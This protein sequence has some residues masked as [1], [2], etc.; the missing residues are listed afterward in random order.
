V[1]AAKPIDDIHRAQYLNFP[2]AIAPISPPAA[3]RHRSLCAFCVFCGS[4]SLPVEQ[5]T[6][7][8][9][10]AAVNPANNILP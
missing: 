4:I 1:K 9:T 2:K 8:A 6:L 5:T 10:K 7:Q 3:Q